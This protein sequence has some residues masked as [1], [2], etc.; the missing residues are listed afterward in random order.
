MPI[1]FDEIQ[2]DTTAVGTVITLKF[3]EKLDKTDYETFVPMIQN[4]IRKGSSIRL[5]AE[6]HDFK[7]WTAGALWEDTKF[8]AKHFKDIERLA[9]AGEARWQKGVTI[10]VKPFTAADV[11]YFDIQEIDK[12]RKWVREA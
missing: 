5:L 9:V 11:R 8:A 7:G 6:L 3:R 12:A 10:F 1:G 4:Q 2:V